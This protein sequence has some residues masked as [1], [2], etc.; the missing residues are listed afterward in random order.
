ML[1]FLKPRTRDSVVRLTRDFV[2][3][4]IVFFRAQ[5]VVAFLQGLLVAIG[6][7]AIGLDYGF[8]I[9]LGLGLLTII[10]YLGTAVGFC[11][12]RC[13]SRGSNRTAGSCSRL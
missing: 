4:L 8:V 9:G 12:S 2:Q 1:P 3:I 7:T 10:P 5:L 6:F 13:R 11:P